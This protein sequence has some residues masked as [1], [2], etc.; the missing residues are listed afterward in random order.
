MSKLKMAVLPD[1]DGSAADVARRAGAEVVG[2]DE[3]EALAWTTSATAEFPA[4]LPDSIRWVQLPSAGVEQWLDAGIIDDARTWTAAIGAYAAP[5]AEHALLLLLAGLRR[6]PDCVRATTWSKSELMPQVG[7]LGGAAVAII[8]CGSIGRALIP[9]L[10]ALGAEVVAVTRSGR[11]VPG[12]ARTLAAADSGEVWSQADHVVI[13]APATSDTRHLVG[14]DQLSRMRPGAW[15]VN[16]ARGSVVDTD[17]LVGALDEGRIGGAALDVTDPE[18][19][20]DDHPLWT[21]PRAIVTPHIA[22]PA[23]TLRRGFHERLAHNIAQ[24]LA[25]RQPAGTVDLVRGY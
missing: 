22:N 1:P 2:L 23:V 24:H 11:D 25:G 9:P 18:P 20:P 13:A 3:A 17:A 10:R 19:L 6:M 15:L 5:V 8:G 14:R 7:T 21:H 4:A 16:V 12:A